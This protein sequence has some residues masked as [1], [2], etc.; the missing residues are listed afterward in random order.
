MVG[1]RVDCHV[2]LRTYAAHSG[3]EVRDAV[4]ELSELPPSRELNLPPTAGIPAQRLLAK[5]GL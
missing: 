3:K 5:L 2:S 4:K 1:V